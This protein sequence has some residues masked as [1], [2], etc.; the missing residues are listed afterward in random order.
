MLRRRLR[1][2]PVGYVDVYEEAQH[3][4]S[5]AT[6]CRECLLGTKG[7]RELIFTPPVEVVTAPSSVT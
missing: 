3:C 5:R 4:N 1:I 7:H 6:V 2:V